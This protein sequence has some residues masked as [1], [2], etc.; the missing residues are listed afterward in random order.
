MTLETKGLDEILSGVEP[1]QEQETVAETPAPETTE[2]QQTE[3]QPRGADG[4]FAPK[5]TEP[6]TSAQQTVEG[7]EQPHERGGVVPQQALHAAREKARTEQDRADRLEQQLAEIRGQ[8]SVLAQQRQPAPAPVEPPKPIEFWDNPQEWGQSLLTPI[9]EQLFETRLMVSETAAIT[10]FGEPALTAAK[11]ALEDAVKAG[12][13]DGKAVQA[14]LRQS[15]DPVG[16][17]VRW[18]QSSPA[19]QEQTMREKLRAELMAEL[20]ID[21]GAKPAPTPEAA[22]PTS[23]AVMPSNLAGRP[24]VGTRSGPAWSG[25]APLNDIFDRTRPKKAG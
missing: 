16:D 24:N 21:P 17:I 6:D 23:S 13:V 3:G 15:R 7:T 22:T 14:Q 4:K 25:P 8:V 5:A 1:V 10:K 20:G 2:P 19:V 18:H 9:Q 11:A 12:Q